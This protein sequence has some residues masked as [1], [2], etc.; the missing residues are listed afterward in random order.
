MVEFTGEKIQ[1]KLPT[2]FPFDQLETYDEKIW[3]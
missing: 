1:K 2:H 3:K